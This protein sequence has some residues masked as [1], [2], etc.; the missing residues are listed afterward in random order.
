MDPAREQ[1]AASKT[2]KSLKVIL[3]AL[4]AGGFVLC[5]YIFV[6]VYHAQQAA[7]SLSSLGG[8]ETQVSQ[9]VVSAPGPVAS[10]DF[11][12]Y[13]EIFERRK[14]FEPYSQKEEAA[15]AAAEPH[16]PGPVFSSWNGKY[17]LVGIILDAAPQVMIEDIKNKETLF[18]KTGDNLEAAALKEIQE[19]RAVFVYANQTFVLTP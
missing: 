8:S 18:L 15:R 4:G 2:E 12:A 19:G 3:R 10:A 14:V 9:A 16:S 6:R 1:G 13:G 7:T 11:S 5:L 17:K